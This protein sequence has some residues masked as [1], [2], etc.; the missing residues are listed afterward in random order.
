MEKEFSH[1]PETFPGLIHT[2][3]SKVQ[4]TDTKKGGRFSGTP[5][6]IFT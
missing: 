1:G 6:F 3:I 5:S 4:D 2:R